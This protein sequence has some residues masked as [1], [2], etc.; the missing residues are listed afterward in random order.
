MTRPRIALGSFMLESNAHSPLA[1]R[2]EFE[3]NVL[4]AP[5]DL[6]ADLRGAHP[7]SPGCLAGF[8][9][10]MSGATWEPVPMI[11]AAVGASGPIEQAFFDEIVASM[12]RS[13]EAA[14]AHAPLDAVFI[15][16][17]GAA[18]ATADPDPD[19]TL[20]AAVRRVVGERVPVAATLDLHGNVSAAM[21]TNA[22][23]L[24]SY[25]TNP[26]VDTHARGAECAR[27]LLRMIE[28]GARPHRAFVKLP[29]IPPSVT[30]NT[31]SGPYGDIIAFGQARAG[32]DVQNVSVLSGFTLGDTPKAGMSVVVSAATAE[33][34]SRTAREV[35]TRAWADRVRYVPHLTSLAEATRMAAAVGRD[36]SLPPL[37]FAD[38]ADNAGGGGRANTVWILEAFHRA[39]VTGCALAIFYDPRVAAQAHA[40]GV[41]ATLQVAF[42][43]DETHP[44][45]G[46]FE[47]DGVVMQL[48]DGRFIGRRGIA[49]GHAIALGPCARI[50]VGGI[51]VIV[52]SVRQ[53]AKDPVFLEDI[54]VDI[55]ALRSLVV[56]SR[57]HFRAAFDE[58]FPDERIVE[59]DV[60]G[61]TTPVLKNVPYEHLPRPIYPLDEDW[62]F[63]VGEP[64]VFAARRS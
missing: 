17:H 41:G 35:A 47:A 3:Q 38:V 9:E 51:D 50:R 37:L 53:Q 7:S 58:F 14:L 52:V 45:S 4:I 49:A 8:F 11:A 60:P 23:Y 15:S 26:H 13:L 2:E 10:A 25:L 24:A 55:A 6:L 1:T 12:T 33:A 56:K 44:L 42:N 18:I 20:L 28:S 57:G 54:G 62:G 63:E 36:R 61:L 39:G 48:H 31:K 43:R 64:Q 34:A 22:D 32:G 19:G 16:L 27:A 5:D 59:V 29:F 46:R 21:V 30:Q 40:A